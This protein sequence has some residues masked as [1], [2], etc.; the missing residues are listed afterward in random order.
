MT[1]LKW[2]LSCHLQASSFFCLNDV[3]NIVLLVWRE[4][5]IVKISE[6]E[7]DCLLASTSHYRLIVVTGCVCKP[8]SEQLPVDLLESQRVRI[9]C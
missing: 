5:I 1:P 9:F 4:E 2:F 3:C 6:L 7:S 8:C